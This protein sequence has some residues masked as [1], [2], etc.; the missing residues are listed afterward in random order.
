MNTNVKKILLTGTALM[1]VSIIGAGAANAQQSI[2]AGTTAITTPTTG[3]VTLTA[4]G[5]IA[6]VADGATIGHNI[7]AG[8]AGFGTVR[9][10]GFG[11]ILNVG[12]SGTNVGTLDINGGNAKTPAFAA[13]FADN[14]TYTGSAGATASFSANSTI[15]NAISLGANTISVGNGATFTATGGI[16]GG[17]GTVTLNS[18]GS[19]AGGAVNIAT[20]NKNISSSTATVSNALTVGA[21]NV[22]AGTLSITNTSSTVSG[23]A[24]IGGNRLN[25][26]GTSLSSVTLSSGGLV[27]LDGANQTVSSTIGSGTGSASMA[28]SGTKTLNGAVNVTTFS[29]NGTLDVA[30]S[31]AITTTTLDRSSGGTATVSNLVTATNTTVQG[32][33]TLTLSNVSSSLGA[34]TF[35]GTG[36]E[37]SGAGITSITG[38]TNLSG[39]GTV[40]SQVNGIAVT[41]NSTNN[42]TIVVS[43]ANSTLSGATLAAGSRL[44]FGGA[45][46]GAVTGAGGRLLLSGTNQTA[47]AVGSAGNALG[48][49]GLASGG[50]NS[51]TG[52]IYANLVE[53]FGGTTS[54]NGTITGAVSNL[55]NGTI[56]LADGAG[57]TGA[58]TTGAGG[59]GNLT[60]A[61]N[62]ALGGAVASANS[63][64]TLTL[65]GDNTK[66]VTAAGVVNA[67][68][69]SIT[70]GGNLA[71]NGAG[72][73]T[74]TNAIGL[75]TGRIT[76]GNGANLI[77]TGGITG[78][79]GT[80]VLDGASS[81]TATGAST[82]GTLNKTGAGTGVLDGVGTTVISSVNVGANALNISNAN[83]SVT[84][85]STIGANTLSFAGTSLG[86]VVG[87]GGTLNLTGTGAQSVGAVGTTGNNLAAVNINGTGTKTFTS[88]V[89]ANTLAFGAGGTADLTAAG[90]SVAGQ[91][92]NFNGNYGTVLFANGTNYTGTAAATTNGRG[93]LNFGNGSTIANTAVIGTNANKMNR[94]TFGTGTNAINAAIH[95]NE[96]HL[97]AGT[98][99]ASATATNLNSHVHFTGDGVLNLA[100]GTTIAGNLDNATA[101]HGTVNYTGPLNINM[102]LARLKKL[103]VTGTLTVGGNATAADEMNVGIQTMN[104]G[105]T[106]ATTANTVLTYRVNT[107][108]TSGKITST[109]QATVDANTAVNMIVDTN[110]YVANGQEFVLI[111]GAESGNHVATLANGK[112]TTT[113]TTLLHFKQ[114]TTDTNN[115]VVYADRTQMT[116]VSN[117]PNNAALGKVLDAAGG[118][119]NTELNAFQVALGQQTT[120]AGVNNLLGSAIPSASSTAAVATPVVPSQTSSIISNAINNAFGNGSSVNGTQ[121]AS[122]SSG[123]GV[124]AGDWSQGLNFWAQAFG[125]TA[126]QD[127][128]DRIAGYDAD[129]YGTVF[130]VDGEVDETLRLGVAVTYGNTDVD[131]KD[132]NRTSTEI[133]S[134]GLS[135]Y[136]GKKLP[137]DFFVGGQ[138]SYFYNDI[139]S[140]RHNVGGVAG[141]TARADYHSDQYGANV[142][143]GRNFLVGGGVTLTPSVTANY[144]YLDIEKYSEKGAGGLNL[145]N[146]KTDEVQILEFGANLKASADIADN[147]GGVITPNIHGGIRHDVIGDDVAT[148]SRLVG[149]GVAFGTRGADPA[150]TTANI[151]TGFSWK[152]Q[153]NVEFSANYDYE[154]KSDYD[155]HS[156]YIRAGYK[157]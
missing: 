106:F 118:S 74:I 76:V 85:T 90:A 31:G 91:A 143:G 150:Q 32:G 156:G 17:T 33:G 27:V 84:G 103:D 129:S 70:N 35:Q 92:I 98:T 20:L 114:K 28:G 111:D 47:G 63:L 26:G 64:N 22:N 144:S 136:G 132:V 79:N 73:S 94:V 68:N 88:A 65:N 87:S 83:S 15:T 107:P 112:L 120:V 58:V 1:A 127:L 155:A 109:G 97:G 108:T 124:A 93:D 4:A 75:G 128:R 105:G 49:L 130:G 69:L 131:A 10:L 51:I 8:T 39:T 57:I 30:G 50:T 38:D 14:L 34:V 113:S 137:A 95:A 82:I 153:S 72:N 134:Y 13:V 62:S 61:G 141:R 37:I 46:I 96:L 115:L 148:S 117:N 145:T 135:L 77:A 23:V 19:L 45:A 139:E 157:F 125:S 12:A 36:G 60:F 89:H 99:T 11:S 66:T 3:V 80:I 154:Y 42:A 40:S 59:N 101:G 138:V 81:L 9:T 78:S 147:N 67:A 116:A 41:N 21:I 25:F 133:D 122:L 151:G 142:E 104:V 71:L 6:T 44:D 29:V 5:S 53:V 102:G 86:A 7:V 43:N 146:V 119:T 16:T 24:A 110:V 52:A 140:A 54:I 121:I 126:N 56:M 152:L 18:T 149:G 100:S 123:A 55:S 2:G 48:N